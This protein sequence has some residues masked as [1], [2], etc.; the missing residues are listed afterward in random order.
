MK[1]FF[2]LV[3]VIPIGPTCNAEYIT[4]TVDSILHYT[5]ASLKIIFADDSQKQ[6]GD[7]LKSIY[8]NA[9]VVTT[10]KSM[11]KLCGLYIN[12]SQAFQHALQHYS[13]TALLRM[14]TDALII[15]DDPVREAVQLFKQHP[16]IGIAGQ[17]P[18]DYNGNEWDKGWPRFQLSRFTH[19]L[20]MWK[21]PLVNFQLRKHYKR[22]V[23]HGYIMGES[24]FGGACFYSNKCLAAMNDAGLLKKE[25]FK[26]LDLE[27][28]HLF[29]ILAKSVG[30]NFGDLSSGNKPFACAWKNLPASPEQLYETHKKI[31]HSVRGYNNIKEPEI[32]RFF[33]QRRKLNSFLTT[34]YL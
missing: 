14:D 6:T 31:I 30:M 32:R 28:D 27:E 10:A 1:K 13:F 3:V 8:T 34:Q 17:Y 29:A 33:R 26:T 24:V 5:T 21:R 25:I 7:L 2:E 4:D 22:A 19:I 16:D 23:K 15:G 18:L 11:G 20:K 12:L 9:D